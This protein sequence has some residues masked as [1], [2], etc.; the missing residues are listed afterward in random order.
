MTFES[1]GFAADG[2]KYKM[3]GD[4]TIKGVTK[5]VTFDLEFDGY[6]PI[7]GATTRRRLRRR[8]RSTARTAASRGT[9]RSRAVA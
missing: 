4:L 8:R 9:R 3:T 6:T 7:R 5:P 2:D 1:T